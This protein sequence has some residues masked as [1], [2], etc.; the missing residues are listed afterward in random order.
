MR[1][2]IDTEFNGCG[3]ELISIARVPENDGDDVGG[4]SVRGV[5]ADVESASLTINL[6]R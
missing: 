2:F 6:P 4:R 3:G 5:A 1:Y